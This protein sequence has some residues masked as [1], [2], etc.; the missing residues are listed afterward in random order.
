LFLNK[1]TAERG[2]VPVRGDLF[3]PLA[4]VYPRGCV[5]LAEAQ[6]RTGDF[7][8]QHFVRSCLDAR[9]LVGFKVGSKEEAL[10]HNLNVPDDLPSDARV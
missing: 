5:A 6:L 1:C 2:I 4:A 7:S 8:L 3:E 9:F 10:F